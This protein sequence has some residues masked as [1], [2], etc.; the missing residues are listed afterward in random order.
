MHAIKFH[1]SDPSL[2]GTFFFNKIFLHFCGCY[3]RRT[4]L[5]IDSL[6]DVSSKIC[7]LFSNICG[8]IMSCH[9]GLIVLGSVR[10]QAEQSPPYFS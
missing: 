7:A 1:E 10:N 4:T 8:N 2:C 3:L 5:E 6:Q 9:P